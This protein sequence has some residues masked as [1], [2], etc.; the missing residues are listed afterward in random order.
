V[1]KHYLEIMP[2]LTNS[3]YLAQHDS[4]ANVWHDN[5]F[6]FAALTSSYQ[7][8]LHDYYQPTSTPT[9]AELFEHRRRVTK[10]RPA[11]PAQARGNGRD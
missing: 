5:K 7:Y 2:R 1:G 3:D 6:V 4:L 11:L 10:L 8:L 9:A